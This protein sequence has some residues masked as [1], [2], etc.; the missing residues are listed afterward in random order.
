MGSQKQA[1]ELTYMDDE[2]H[3]RIFKECGLLYDPHLEITSRLVEEEMIR[4]EH[5]EDRRNKGEL[6]FY[7]DTKGNF[8]VIKKTYSSK[9]Y[10]MVVS[11]LTLVNP[12]FDGLAELVKSY[13]LPFESEIVT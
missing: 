7:F 3:V 11:R 13:N 2:E 6:D 1:Y 9:L 5:I 4:V 12:T 8:A 10:R